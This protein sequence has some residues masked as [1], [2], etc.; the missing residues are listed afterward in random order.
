MD[1]KIYEAC[2]RKQE[3][4]KNGEK[5]LSWDELAEVFDI[6]S[7]KILKD[8]FYRAKNKKKYSE[9]PSNYSPESEGEFDDNSYKLEIKGDGSQISDKLIWM[10]ENE[11]KSKD[12]VLNAHGYDPE[13]WELVNAESNMWQ[14]LRP[15]DAGARTLFKSK[16]TVRPKISNGITLK[17]IDTFLSS[18]S[19]KEGSRKSD[20]RQYK[21]GGMV[22]EVVLADV[23]VSNEGIPAET[24]QKRVETVVD[25]VKRRTN[26]YQL[27]EIILVQL[28]D[29]FHF[30]N[31]NRQTTSGTQVTS[32]GNYPN[33]FNSGME[34]MVY[35]IDELS[36]ITKV[37]MVNIFGNHDKVTSYALSK[38]LEAY[39]R[40]NE[41]VFIDTSQGVVKF[42]E[43]G[44]NSVAF[45]HGD[46]PKNNIY[47]AF[48][49]DE[50]G[51]EIFGRTKYSEIHIGHLHHENSLEKNGVISRW[52]PSIT[53]PDEWHIANGYKGAKQGT[54]CFLWD[55]EN[56]LDSIWMIN[57]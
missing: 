13:E 21:S 39:Y 42:E 44:V 50:V 31:Y 20:I 10:F 33:M 36:S 26:G 38:T 49:T 9:S 32:V 2:E 34:L 17:D 37:K 4:N 41:N 8:R 6:P 5:S 27:E 3:K 57:F 29:I 52:M 7:G 47:G 55:K 23:H 22:L 35:V 18:Y 46:M 43:I 19:P 40:N 24:L 48:Y 16:I 1:T 54:Q 12:F 28:G 14:G 56:G 45:L 53:S 51:R 11:S 15:K 25:E 30:D